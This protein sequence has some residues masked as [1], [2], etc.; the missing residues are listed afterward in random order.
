MC[1]LPQH[2]EFN[3]ELEENTPQKCDIVVSLI[4]LNREKTKAVGWRM[5]SPAVSHHTNIYSMKEGYTHTGRYRYAHVAEEW[6]GFCLGPLMLNRK[7]AGAYSKIFQRK[8]GKGK[9]GNR[10]K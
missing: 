1:R 5:S 7:I 8:M 6:R 4:S 2:D 10:K 3:T 9:K